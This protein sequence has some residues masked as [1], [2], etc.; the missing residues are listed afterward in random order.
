MT[1]GE[2]KAYRAKHFKAYPELEEYWAW[3]K[4]QLK[5]KDSNARTLINPLGRKRVFL[6]RLD[7]DTFREAYSDYAQGTVA[8][9]LRT[10]MVRVHRDLVLPVRREHP[11]TRVVL[12]VHDAVLMQYPIELRDSFTRTGLELMKVP[13]IINDKEITIPT[14]AEYGPT[15]GDMSKWSNGGT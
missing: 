8:V 12:E 4:E 9:V 6:G 7:N 11:H 5:R 13:M 3:I 14:S 15:W 2:A 10:G 1:R